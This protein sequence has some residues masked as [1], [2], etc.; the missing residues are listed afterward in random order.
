MFWNEKFWL[1]RTNFVELT[2]QFFFHTELFC[3]IKSFSNPGSKLKIQKVANSGG[4][5][6]VELFIASFAFISLYYRTSKKLLFVL[7]HH[8]EATHPT[9]TAY[10]IN[11]PYGPPVYSRREPPWTMSPPLPVSITKPNRNAGNEGGRGRGRKRASEDA[12]VGRGDAKIMNMRNARTKQRR[13]RELSVAWHLGVV[14]S[15]G[16][17]KHELMQKDLQEEGL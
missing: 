1:L 6:S 8:T 4:F 16:K 13:R 2:I 7:P 12:E 14:Q 3:S 11:Y 5:R 15:A 9:L 17:V 10:P